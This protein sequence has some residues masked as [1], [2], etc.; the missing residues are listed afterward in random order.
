MIGKTFYKKDSSRLSTSRLKIV[1]ESFNS[2][3][4]IPY[5]FTYKKWGKETLVRTMTKENLLKNYSEEV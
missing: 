3:D 5:N 2:V 4:V 1:A